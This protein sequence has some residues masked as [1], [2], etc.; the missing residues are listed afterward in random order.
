[1]RTARMMRAQKKLARGSIGGAARPGYS[2][3]A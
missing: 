2:S 3:R 1:M